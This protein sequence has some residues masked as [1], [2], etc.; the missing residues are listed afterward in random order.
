MTAALVINLEA[1]PHCPYGWIIEEHRAG[2]PS[3]EWDPTKLA[4]YLEEGQQ[5]GV[6]QGTELREK[7]KGKAIL[8]ATLLDYLLAHPELIPD[9]WKGK[10]IFFWGTIYRGSPCVLG[11]RYLYWAGRQWCSA[12]VWLNGDFGDSHPALVSASNTSN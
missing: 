12:C 11:V 6:V 1:T 8:N 4:L 7:L 3:L 5:T 2:D 10:A 9:D